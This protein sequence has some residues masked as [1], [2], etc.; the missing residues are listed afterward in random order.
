[1]VAAVNSLREQVGI[2]EVAWQSEFASTKYKVD[3]AAIQHFLDGKDSSIPTHLITP[4]LH[5]IITTIRELILVQPSCRQF[6]F[7]KI[8]ANG[9]VGCDLSF[10][11]TDKQDADLLFRMNSVILPGQLGSEKLAIE[12]IR[13]HVHPATR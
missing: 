10:N 12:Y 4:V 9:I 7:Q 1:M 13:L 2:S 11:L 3:A 6:T 5:S 8:M